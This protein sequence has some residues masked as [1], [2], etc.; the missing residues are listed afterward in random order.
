[1]KVAAL[2]RQV[3]LVVLAY[4]SET[5]ETL[6]S[7]GYHLHDDKITYYDASVLLK[8]VGSGTA[9]QHELMILAELSPLCS[10]GNW[11]GQIAACLASEA[12]VCIVK[13]IH[14][15]DKKAR[16]KQD[17]SVVSRGRGRKGS[18]LGTTA[19]ARRTCPPVPT[20]RCAC[21]ERKVRRTSSYKK[22]RSPSL[23]T[24]SGT[25]CPLCLN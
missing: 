13:F 15:V 7:E 16:V 5:S 21:V 19:G 1:M 22:R 23:S 3:K 10:N 14:P 8:F 17:A 4:A 25:G 24:S 9:T 6:V 2:Y 12:L 20:R 11:A 18:T